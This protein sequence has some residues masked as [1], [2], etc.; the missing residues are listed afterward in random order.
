MRRALVALILAAMALPGSAQED[1]YAGK[2]ASEDFY[3]S[4]E[5]GWSWYQDPRPAKPRPPQPA[6]PP[7]ASAA[8]PP[9]PATKAAP[10]IFSSAWLRENFERLRDEAMDDPSN[11]DKVRAYMYA[12]RVALDKSQRFANA[13]STVAQTDPLL[14]ER[15]RIPLDTAAAAAVAQGVGKRKQ[16][17]IKHL[18]TVGGLLFFF[19]STCEHCRTQFQALEWLKRD[20]NFTV[21]NI[22]VDGKGLPGMPPS[23][24]VRDEGQA[25]ALRLSIMPT[26][27]YAV[28]PD[29]FY[30]ISQGYYAAET[31]GEKMLLAATTDKLLPDAMTKAISTY[32]R[33]VLTGEDLKDAAVDA[34]DSKA[35]VEALRKKLGARY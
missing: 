7:A 35:W 34:N 26:T 12:Q 13:A 29:K 30:I 24:W 2:S 21:K 5:W 18:A 28:P 8:P 27:I 4:K 6:P 16:E 10:Q 11:T 33:G 15:N 14:D 32:D 31:L 22:S 19:D 20:Y 25:K 9:A 17:A 1:F 23:M 3:S